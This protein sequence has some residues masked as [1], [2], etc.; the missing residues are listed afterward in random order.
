[1]Q[2]S[3]DFKFTIVYYLTKIISDRARMEKKENEN[4]FFQVV[5]NYT[6]RAGLYIIVNCS[7]NLLYFDITISFLYLE[8][9]YNGVVWAHNRFNYFSE[10]REKKRGFLPCFEWEMPECDCELLSCV[11]RFFN[12]FSPFERLSLT[13][14]FDGK[15]EKKSSYTMVNVTCYHTNVITN[16]RLNRWLIFWLSYEYNRIISFLKSLSIKKKKKNNR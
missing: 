6:S 10:S 12:S 11:M 13:I 2:S 3:I 16:C 5:T 7:A 1:M 14:S 4:R 15:I 8:G 9:D